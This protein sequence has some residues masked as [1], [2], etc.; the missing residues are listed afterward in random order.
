MKS[1]AT[2]SRNRS[3]AEFNQT[4]VS[5]K[6]EVEED[7]IIQAHLDALYDQLLEKNLCRVIEPF[8]CVEITHVAKVIELPLTTVE[9]KLSQ[10]ILDKKLHGELA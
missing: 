8:S 5:Y 10:M 6:E 3:I 9:R 7:P 4:L 1:V 2:A